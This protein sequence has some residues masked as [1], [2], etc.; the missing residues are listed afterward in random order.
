MFDLLN[1]KNKFCKTPGR[2]AITKEDLRSLKEKVEYFVN[3]IGNLQFDEETVIE[4][5]NVE[6]SSDPPNKK[7]RKAKRTPSK[8]QI[9]RKSVLES[10]QTRTGFL[11][12]IICLRNMISLSERLFEKNICIYIDL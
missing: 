3:Y 12:F 9:G 10:P 2:K 7:G 8:Y 11:G 6:P 4:Y 1:S 5:Q